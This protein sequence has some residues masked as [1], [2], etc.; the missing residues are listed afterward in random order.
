MTDACLI[1]SNLHGFHMILT[2]QSKQRTSDGVNQNN[3][4]LEKG[5]TSKEFRTEKTHKRRTG[6]TERTFHNSMPRRSCL[7]P[8]RPHPDGRAF[9]PG[10]KSVISVRGQGGGNR[11]VR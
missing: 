7:I 6:E 5:W 4:I 3:T 11:R 2:S 1:A 9:E 8:K 10:D